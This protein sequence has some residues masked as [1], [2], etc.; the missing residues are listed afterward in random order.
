MYETSRSNRWLRFVAARVFVIWLNAIVA[1]S[2]RA[3][4]PGV[5]AVMVGCPSRI[6]IIR[7]GEKPPEEEK[8]KSLSSRGSQRALQLHEL[9][10]VSEKRP[11]PLPIPDFVFATAESKHSRRPIETVQR[12]VDQKK[13][14]L[15][16][17]FA[18]EEIVELAREIFLNQK[19]K[20]KVILISWHHGKAAALAKALHAANSPKDWDGE[21]VFDRVWEISYDA[22]GKGSFAN[23]PQHLLPGDTKD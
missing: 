1:C 21:G 9:F 15:N 2:V 20:G 7:H 5:D 19:Y 4:A 10:E 11:K 16:T 14:P 17:R 3:E 22:N 13:I 18:D 23:R 6:L 8:S 12:L